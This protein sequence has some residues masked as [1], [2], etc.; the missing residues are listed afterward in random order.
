[1][2]NAVFGW[3]KERGSGVLLHP[4]ALPG[5]CGIGTLGREA[6]RLI[7]FIHGAGMHYW[8]ICPL[9]PTGYGN[10][11]YM[12]YSVF[13]GNANLIDLQELVSFGLLEDHELNGLRSLPH[14]RVDY[15]SVEKLKTPLLNQAFE[16]F[17]TSGKPGLPGYLS[18]RAF[19]KKNACWLPP[20]TYYM[21]LKEFCKG[22]PWQ[23]WSD[24][25][26][27][28]RKA[29][30]SYLKEELAPLSESYAFTQYVFFNQWRKLKEYA[31]SHNVLVIGDAPIFPALDSA[32]TW[33][34]PRFFQLKKDGKPKAVAGVPPDYF[35]KTG[36][37]WGNPLYDWEALKADD[38]AWWMQRMALNF[39]LYDVVRLD[40]FRGFEACWRVPAGA[41]DARA[42][43]WESGPGL[44]FLEKIRSRFPEAKI[45]AED[46]G[47]IT[48][49]LQSFLEAFGL[50]GM[51]VLQFAFTLE[52]ENFYL[53][54]NHWRNCVVYPGTHDNDTTL[55]WWQNQATPD[56]RDH[57]RRYFRISGEEISWDFIRAAFQSVSRLAIFPLQDLLALGSEARF[58]TPGTVG[59]NWQWRCTREQLDH[60]CGDPTLYLRELAWLYKR[61]PSAGAP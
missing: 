52:P 19:Q 22:I 36:Q 23:E 15:G 9:G 50:P 61:Y 35:S 60:L 47:L 29:E 42:G 13:A 4:T 8:Q 30:Q 5:D 27:D 40:H 51:A 7:D 45:I 48:P 56:I 10:S 31:N 49:E 44:P 34:H 1:M 46:L 53:P 37:L 57:V 11:P 18:F 39:D 43:H 2:K 16:R 54:H 14:D 25:I 58:N 6:R 3:L 26:R 59:G 32:D 17:Q 41:K 55:G 28:P 21:A 24:A 12:C 33:A 20:F 38:Y